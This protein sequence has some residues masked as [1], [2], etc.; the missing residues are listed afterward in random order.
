MDEVERFGEALV[1]LALEG[2]LVPEDESRYRAALL[3]YLGVALAGGHEPSV[4][5]FMVVTSRVLL[6][7]GLIP[8]SQLGDGMYNARIASLHAS[9]AWRWRSRWPRGRDR[10][11]RPDPMAGSRGAARRGP[12]SR[13]PCCH[14]GLTPRR[15]FA[16]THDAMPWVPVSAC[17]P[18]A[19][20]ASE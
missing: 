9:D 12:S 7:V 13:A 19:A 1:G 8:F 14:G 15:V 17:A 2:H 18:C 10:G 4:E 20:M 11:A 5:V 6:P 3:N 16:F